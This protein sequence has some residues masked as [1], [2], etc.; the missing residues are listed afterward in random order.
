MQA[1]GSVEE[2]GYHQYASDPGQTSTAFFVA[3][4]S[5]RYCVPRSPTISEAGII[6]TQL[7]WGHRAAISINALPT[8]TTTLVFEPSSSTNIT[9]PVVIDTAHDDIASAQLSF[10]TDGAASADRRRSFELGAR[11]RK[12]KGT[13]SFKE[14]RERS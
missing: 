10:V 7:T 11:K 2:E 14:S 8:T 6:A 4:L 13:R 3:D 5:F 1:A 12:R 9:T